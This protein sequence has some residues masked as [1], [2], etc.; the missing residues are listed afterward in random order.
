MEPISIADFEKRVERGKKEFLPAPVHAQ[1]VVSLRDLTKIDSIVIM[2]KEY[3]SMLLCAVTLAG[4]ATV[5]PYKACRI[6]IRRLDPRGMSVGQT[7]VQ[8]SKLLSFLEQFDTHMRDHWV[9]G[10]IAK[11]MP[12]IAF[13]VSRAGVPAIAHYLPPI[14]ELRNHR[15]LVDGTHRNFVVMRAGTTIETIHVY[16][17]EC[18]LPCTAVQWEEVV[19]VDEKPPRDERFRDFQPK[20]FRDFKSIGIDG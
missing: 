11:L 19:V 9:T 7:F 12:F 6:E 1:A 16:N 4:D 17:V 13:G 5:R 14:V 8:R 20:F 3:L 2:S 10:G 15:V 18:A